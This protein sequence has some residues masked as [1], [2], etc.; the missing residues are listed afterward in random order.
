MTVSQLLAS[1]D[2]RELSEW[3]VSSNLPYWRQRLDAKRALEPPSA[4]EIIQIL[5][6]KALKIPGGVNYG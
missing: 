4:S 5:F 2:S 6:G 1:T 3:L